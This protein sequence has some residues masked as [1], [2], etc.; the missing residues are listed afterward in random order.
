[1]TLE[2]KLA[3]ALAAAPRGSPAIDF[4]AWALRV[5]THQYD[6]NAPYRAFCDRRGV[7]P[8][9][10]ARWVDVPAVPTAAFRRLDLACGP[11]E[12]T[13]RTSG[14]TGGPD[15]R[16]RHLVPMLGLYDAAALA[17]FERFVLPDAVRLPCVF[18]LP[19]PTVRPDSSLVHMC[20]A[21]G[22]ALAPRA[23]WYVGATGLELDRLLDRLAADQRTGEAVLLAGPTAAFVALFDACRARGRE[24]RLGPGSRVMDT[25]GQ[26][27]LARPVSRAGFLRS[28]WTAL[29]IPA[30]L[31]IN[32]YGM[33]ELCSQRYDSVLEERF[34]G[35]SLEPRRL[36]APPW[37]RTRVLDPDTLAPVAPGTA[38]LLCHHDLANAGSVSAVLTEDLGRT[39]ADD[40]I[41]VLGRVAGAP[42]RGCGL[43]LA[44]LG[45]A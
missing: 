25:G 29:G 4:E 24:L 28:C 18:L 6:R 9:T 15:A 11:A 14:T 33:T 3:A 36:V 41:E 37:L 35:R 5:F 12:A 43:L 13:F 16:G 40:G 23:D 17:A 45:G 10:V 2:D 26:K 27:G 44:E 31:C 8:R 20:A 39:V 22:A 1:M 38:G 19:P 30:Y 21:V 34:R 7:T 32:E 42:P